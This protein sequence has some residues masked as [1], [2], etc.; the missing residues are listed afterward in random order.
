MLARIAVV[1]PIQQPYAVQGICI[2]IMEQLQSVA[3]HNWDCVPASGCREYLAGL[4]LKQGWSI[5][6]NSWKKQGQPLEKTR[7]RY[8]C[9]FHT[10]L[11]L[12]SQ[13]H[14]Q[15]PHT[16]LFTYTAKARPV[17]RHRSL[18]SLISAASPF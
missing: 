5:I 15:C 8:L 3:L 17:E 9:P 12:A 13:L 16:S 14:L 10:L 1:F 6:N 18:G 7:M 11:V 2:L 4:Y